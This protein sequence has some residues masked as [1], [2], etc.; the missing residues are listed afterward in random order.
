MTRIFRLALA[1]LMLTTAPAFAATPPK[2]PP[3]APTEVMEAAPAAMTF[4]EVAT[5]DVATGHLEALDPVKI[6][7]FHGAAS[8][9]VDNGEANF[10]LIDGKPVIKG[11]Y[12]IVSNRDDIK[13]FSASPALRLRH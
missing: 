5:F 10:R 12:F 13:P 2:T 1:A 11:Q 9:R 3:S 8:M 6:P 4:V 7:D